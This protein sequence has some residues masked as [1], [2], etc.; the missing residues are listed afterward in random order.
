MQASPALAAPAPVTV[1]VLGHIAR[2]IG[3]DVNVVFYLIVI[4]L[5]AV[6][7]A[8]KTFGLAALVLTAVA[9]VPVIFVL[10]LWVTLP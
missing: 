4:A 1:P 5:T 8:V 2:D 7:L 10:L 9:L 3:R 6:V